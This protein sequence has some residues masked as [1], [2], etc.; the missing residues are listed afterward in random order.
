MDRILKRRLSPFDMLPHGELR[1]KLVE[2]VLYGEPPGIDK[3]TAA[4]FQSLRYRL[5]GAPVEQVKVVVFG[6]GTGLSNIIGGDSRSVS[7]TRAPFVGLKEFF[8]Q[9]RS[10][11]C[12]TDDGGSTGE[13]LKDIPL[14]ALGDIRHVLLSSIQSHR[15]QNLYGLSAVEALEVV[16]GLA[17]L[18]NYRF[19]SHPGSVLALFDQCC[20]RLSCLPD[21]LAKLLERLLDFIFSDIRLSVCLER[22]HCLGNLILAA[23]IYEEL[24]V[25]LSSAD[26]VAEPSPLE[27]A[28]QKGL[29]KLYEPLGICDN[30]VLPSTATQAQLSFLYANG[31]QVTGEHKSGF[32]RRGVP[33]EQVFS[34]FC[35]EPRVLPEVI[36]LIAEA[37]I[38]VMAPGSLYSSLIPILQVPG[39]ADAVR[40]N[41]HA[42]KILVSNLWAQG[43]ETDLSIS[44]PE[45]RFYVSDTLKA[46]EK[47]IPGG[48]VG[49]FD[50]VICLSL[51]DVPGSILQEYAL[52]GKIPIYLDRE[53]VSRQGFVPLECGIFSQEALAEKG[54]IQHDPEQL[55]RVVKTL[56]V[57]CREL[58]PVQKNLFERPVSS[59]SS[60]IPSFCEPSI[61]RYQAIDQQLDQ[62]EIEVR[63]RGASPLSVDKVRDELTEIL[64]SHKDIPLDHLGNVTGLCCI[65]G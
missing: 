7:W 59:D 61:S 64:W 55:A 4:S 1:E 35:G 43:G 48:T 30:G 2:L 52:E 37:D 5:A 12:V 14:I 18:F 28:L 26:L 60:L 57:I 23:S 8:P 10:V 47:N 56:W 13:L 19:S 41:A 15:L 11:V 21:P 63:I 20:V 58:H 17:A 29:A 25:E 50:Q 33:V 53:Q 39:I 54:V 6:G 42:L 9:T 36:N 40:S 65:D 34:R 16:R 32:A 24:P 51:K 38:I 3:E 45:R 22:K 31:V 46:Y 27:A 49:L 44:D 62:L